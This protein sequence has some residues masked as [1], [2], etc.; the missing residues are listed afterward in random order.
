MRDS[1]TVVLSE[2]YRQSFLALVV[3]EGGG[4]EEPV[5]GVPG[6]FP[7][8]EVVLHD[9]DGDAPA[10]RQRSAPRGPVPALLTERHPAHR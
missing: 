5:P 1:F 2:E 6:R 4:Y 3:H 8:A 10:P 7:H 9:R